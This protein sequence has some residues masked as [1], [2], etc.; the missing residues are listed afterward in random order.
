MILVKFTRH[1]KNSEHMGIFALINFIFFSVVIFF[2]L[3]TFYH[4]E[5]GALFRIMWNI[6]ISPFGLVKFRHFFMADILCSMVKPIQD[7]PPSLVYL[8]TGKFIEN[9]YVD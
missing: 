2:P 6:F 3:K 8:F 7:I 5:R 4:R 1:R 9:E